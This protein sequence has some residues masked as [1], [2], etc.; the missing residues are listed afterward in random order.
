[1]ESQKRG[2]WDSSRRGLSGI[3]KD[4]SQL[5]YA[6]GSSDGDKQGIDQQHTGYIR[7]HI[8]AVEIKLKLY[9]GEQI[10]HAYNYCGTYRMFLANG[11]IYADD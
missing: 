6:C 8:S 11:L 10:S 2:C 5:N 1:M 7:P 9:T 3:S 4:K